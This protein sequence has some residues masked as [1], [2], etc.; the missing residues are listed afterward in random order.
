MRST[1]TIVASAMLAVT[2]VQAQQT[3]YGQCGGEN[4][5]GATTCVSG[6]TCTYLNDWYSQCLPASSSSTLTTTTSPET[7]TTTTVSKSTTSTLS[8]PTSTG[9]LKWFGVDESCAEFGTAMP[10]TWGVDYTFAD[11]TTIGVCFLA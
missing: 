9:K 1:P 7:S 6:W 4:W 11:T 10:G 2:S 3:G 8:S 5:T